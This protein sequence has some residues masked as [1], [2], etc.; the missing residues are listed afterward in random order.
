MSGVSSGTTVHPY[1]DG[2]GTSTEWVV[3][4]GGEREV[5]STLEFFTTDGEAMDVIVR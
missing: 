4:A 1:L 5:H 2:A 3:S